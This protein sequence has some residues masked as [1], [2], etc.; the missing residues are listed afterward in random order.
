ME[1]PED[2]PQAKPVPLQLKF[3]NWGLGSTSRY[4]RGTQVI[5][6]HFPYHGPYKAS[7]HTV[8]PSQRPGDTSQEE[9]D[10]E[11][12]ESVSRASLDT[13]LSF[14]PTSVQQQQFSTSDQGGNNNNGDTPSPPVLPA[15]GSYYRYPRPDADVPAESSGS[16]SILLPYVPDIRETTRS[17][18]PT[19][20]AEIIA[21]T[22]LSPISPFVRVTS[23]SPTSADAKEIR[24]RSGSSSG[25]YSRIF[26]LTGSNVSSS[27][28][29]NGRGHRGLRHASSRRAR[30]HGGRGKP[31]YDRMRREQHGHQF[32]PV[33][34]REWAI[35]DNNVQECLRRFSID[36]ASILRRDRR[37]RITCCREDARYIYVIYRIMYLLGG[38]EEVCSN[39]FIS[40]F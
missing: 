2:I 9:R 25:R 11:A 34:V 12:Y 18:T 40:F 30:A 7:V 28:G 27:R 38:F 1:E 37:I 33:V 22:S 17:R 23:Y 8:P 26:D 35:G 21:T 20:T 39:V 36:E 4:L 5:V 16:P 31:T 19:S 14:L 3:W 29:G 6:T 13:S 24:R 10:S 15:I 32:T